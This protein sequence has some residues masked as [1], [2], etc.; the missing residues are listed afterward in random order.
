VYP[1]AGWQSFIVGNINNNSLQ[2]I[3]NN[4]ERVRYL[5][6]LRY[7][8]FLK[9]LQCAEKNFCTMCMVRNANENSQGDPLIVNEYFCDIAKLNRKIL[10]EWKKKL[11]NQ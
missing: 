11:M 7:K 3:W 10:F 8:D 5:R 9:C 6:E 1:C 2:Y 4:S